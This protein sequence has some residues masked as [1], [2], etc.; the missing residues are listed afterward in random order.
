MSTRISYK[1]GLFAMVFFLMGSC[2]Q[3]IYEI[4]EINDIEVL[5][6]NAYKNKAKTDA[7]YVSILYTNFFQVPIGPNNLLQALEAIR[8]IGD[9]QIAYDMLVSKYLNQSTV[10]PSKEE[11]DAD[12]ESFVRGTYTRFYTRQPTEAEL[13]WML[14]FLQSN[15]DMTPDLFYFAFATSNEHYYY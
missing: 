7:Q 3:D 10:I 14:N 2:T 6:V 12:P 15:P 11:M 1:A 8:S 4:Y 9:K 13:A 5:P